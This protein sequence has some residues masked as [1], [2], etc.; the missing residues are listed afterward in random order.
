MEGHIVLP[1]D[2]GGFTVREAGLLM[3]AGEL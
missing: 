1:S 2:V 3:D